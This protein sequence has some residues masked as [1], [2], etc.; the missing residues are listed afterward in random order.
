MN[1]LN[2]FEFKKYIIIIYLM[3]CANLKAV[4]TFWSK[5]LLEGH[6]RLTRKRDFFLF[7]IYSV[8]W[9]RKWFKYIEINTDNFGEN[10]FS[11]F[12]LSDVKINNHLDVLN[13]LDSFMFWAYPKL[14]SLSKQSEPF[15]HLDGDVF[16]LRKLKDDLFNSET[17]FQC[18]EDYNYHN[19][20]TPLLEK[21][22]ELRKDIVPYWKPDLGYALNCGVMHFL[23]PKLFKRFHENCYNSFIKTDQEY[24][25]KFKN[26]INQTSR[27]FLSYCLLFEQYYL[28]SFL[29]SNKISSNLIFS[30]EDIQIEL[31]GE[32]A[33]QGYI[34]L[35][36]DKNNPEILKNIDKR[37]SIEFPEEYFI[38]KNLNL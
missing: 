19:V 2:I 12:N 14:Y 3:T 37:F 9:S 33:M 5:P 7:F 36:E 17:A 21:N 32:L 35:I 27:N 34:H 4:Y 23:D 22:K 26:F 24:I 29:D 15:V 30:S 18:L 13:D 31:N 6:S 11:K 10:I 1:I 38:L 16:L 28:A 8:L 20:Y 25:A